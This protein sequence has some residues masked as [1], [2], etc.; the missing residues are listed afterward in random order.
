MRRRALLVVGD[1]YDPDPVGGGRLEEGMGQ[2]HD[3]LPLCLSLGD[4]D[5]SLG[6]DWTD[7]DY[8]TLKIVVPII[9]SM[10]SSYRPSY[11]HFSD[12]LNSECTAHTYIQLC[13]YV[14]QI[15]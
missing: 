1:G 14:G 9:R 15:V 4:G 2:G 8:V 13:M 11:K 5:P 10:Y 12:H 7:L 6:V 3:R